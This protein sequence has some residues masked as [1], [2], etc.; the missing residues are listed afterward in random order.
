MPVTMSWR[1]APAAKPT[2][3]A[4]E[5]AGLIP[6]LSYRSLL[7]GGLQL[8]AV[9]CLLAQLVIAP[10]ADNIDCVAMVVLTSSLMLQYLWHSEAMTEYPLSSLALL[11]FTASS[12]FVALVSQTVDG[13]PF[14]EHLRAPLLTFSV[15]GVAHLSAL[16]AHF[17]YRKFL[18]LSGSASFIATRLYAPMNIHRIPTPAA[19]WLLGGIGMVSFIGGGGDMGDV[20]GKFLAALGFLVWMPFMLPLYRDLLGERY[21]SIKVHM[22]FIIGWALVIAAVAVARNNRATIFVGPVQLAI[23]FLVFKCREKQ[24][25]STRFIKNLVLS[26]VAMAVLMPQLSDLMLAMQ[27]TR[28]QRGTISAKEQLKETLDVFVDKHRIHQLRE[29][30]LASVGTEMYDEVYLSNA[31]MSRFTETKF[32]DNML[33]F[34]QQFG[35]EEKAGIIDHQLLRVVALLPQ[36]VL[37]ALDIKLD[38]YSLG[39]SNGDFYVNRATGA[40]M[41]SFLTGS[42]WADIHVLTGSW[43]PMATLVLL[44]MIFITLDSL[45]RFEP[46]KFISPIG[47]C[48]AYMV[49][50]NGVGG[51]SIFT[52]FSQV[53]RGNLQQVLLYAL[54]SLAVVQALRMLGWQPWATP[55]HPNG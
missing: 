51:D 17:I 4:P 14:V 40:P 37:D 20:G 16:L 21:A 2:L 23:V 9:V 6:W 47:L 53:T 42:V 22:P 8:L 15:L 38:K 28:E 36:N 1:T 19:V 48:T 44:W 30:G 52:K 46:G 13:A 45:T 29:A 31:L 43:M 26:A 12:Q 27:I 49:Y 34:G 7:L 18:P 35:D 54:A 32:H 10:E 39:Y 41:G 50:L 11:G 55:K 5:A 3:A 33:F 25:V 24:L